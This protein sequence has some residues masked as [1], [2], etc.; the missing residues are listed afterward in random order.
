M[1][2]PEIKPSTTTKNRGLTV[3]RS[4]RAFR[5]IESIRSDADDDAVNID[6][7]IVVEAGAVGIDSEVAAEERND[8][9]I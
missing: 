7:G 1:R 4:H 5:V 9:G 6:D 8:E 2:A 3:A